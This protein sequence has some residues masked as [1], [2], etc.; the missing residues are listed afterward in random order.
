MK[1]EIKASAEGHFKNGLMC[2]ESVVVTLTKAHGIESELL[3]KAATAFCGG[4]SRTCGTCGALTGAV[5]GISAILGREGAGESYDAP[6]QAAG[7]VIKKFEEEFG[8]RNCNELLG[9]DLGTAEGQNIFKENRLY[10]RCLN[11]TGRAAELAEEILKE[12]NGLPDKGFR[13]PV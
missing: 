7:T 6:F 3:P 8:T 11:Y 10:E 13:K 5:M 9:C 2:A 4:M 12:T 1:D